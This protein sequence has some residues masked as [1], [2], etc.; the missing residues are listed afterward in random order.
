MRLTRIFTE[1]P[2]AVGETYWQHLTHA[3]GFAFWMTVG[4]IACLLHA[5]FPFTCVTT[6][7]GIIRKLHDRMVVNRTQASATATSALPQ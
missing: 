6:G 1:H 2:A 7:S 5:I 4:G 3:A